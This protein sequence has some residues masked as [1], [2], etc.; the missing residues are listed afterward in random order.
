MVEY[1]GVMGNQDSVTVAW[2]HRLK[3]SD[4]IIPTVRVRLKVVAIFCSKVLNSKSNDIR[5]TDKK[6]VKLSS[7]FKDGE[8][9]YPQ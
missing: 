2:D 3:A 7:T 1:P 9:A 6:M 5:I 8:M 4:T